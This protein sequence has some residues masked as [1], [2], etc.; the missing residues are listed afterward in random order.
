MTDV[1]ARPRA[2]RMAPAARREQLL[3]VTLELIARHGYGA[4]NMEAIARAA[5]VTKPVVYDAFGRL[6]DLLRALLER[7]RNRAFGA[8]AAAL[9]SAPDGGAPD[10][11]LVDGLVSFLTAVRTHP[12]AWRLILT[13]ALQTPEPVRREVERG[14]AVVLEQLQPVVAWGLPQ[15]GLD[16]SDPELA[17]HALVALAEAWAQLVLRDPDAYPPERI[18]AFA[19]AMIAGGQAGRRSRASDTKAS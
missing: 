10:D 4:V 11:L 12:T 13:P 5:G 6:E 14:R 1:P 16:P 18:A 9:P 7:E 3:D 8:L 17:A 2:P 19:R 15:L